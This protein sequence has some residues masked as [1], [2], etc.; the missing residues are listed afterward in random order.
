MYHGIRDVHG[1]IGIV[2]QISGVIAAGVNFLEVLYVWE[3]LVPP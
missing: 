1:R 2:D 3:F